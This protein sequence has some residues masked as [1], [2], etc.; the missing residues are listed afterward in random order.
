M[1]AKVVK[2]LCG[3]SGS[4]IFLMQKKDKVF[5]RKVGNI[6][7]NVER[8]YILEKDFPLPKIY[9]YSKNKFD[10]EYIH[11]LD[12]LTYL[13]THDYDQLTKFLIKIFDKLS[14]D[15]CLKDYTETYRKRLNTIIIEEKFPFTKEELLEK[16]PKLLPQSN[17]HGD[18]TL[19][20][21]LWK[22]DRGFILIDCQSSEFDS[23]IFDIAKLRQDL[24]CAWFARKEKISFDGKLKS[25]QEDLFKK[26]PESNN[27]YLLIMMLLRVYQYSKSDTLERTF[28]IDRIKKLWK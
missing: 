10:M 28:L 26:Y 8:S 18:L 22:D 2:E 14:A 12:M 15:N 19:E 1:A 9:N 24:E 3:F 16:L 7:R 5:V 17:Y 4:Q 6:I 11:G 27:D 13:K 23:Y 25:I 20:N 21:I